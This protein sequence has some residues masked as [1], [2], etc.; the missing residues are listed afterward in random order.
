MGGVI[1]AGIQEEGNPSMPVATPI[2]ERSPSGSTSPQAAR[3]LTD[4]A[5]RTP[6]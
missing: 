4:E 5:R 2:T 6:R 1:W 3:G